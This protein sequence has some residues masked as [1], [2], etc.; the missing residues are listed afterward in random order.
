[1]SPANA[2]ELDAFLALTPALQKD[3]PDEPE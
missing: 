2:S 1:V 3:K